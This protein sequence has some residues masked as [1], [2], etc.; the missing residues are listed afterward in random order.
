MTTRLSTVSAALAAGWFLINLTGVSAEEPASGPLKAVTTP[1]GVSVT[2]GDRPVLFYQSAPK[3]LNGRYE[4][5]N[6]IHPLYDLDGNVLTEDFPKDH[7]HQRGIYWAWHQVWVGDKRIGDPWAIQDFGWNVYRIEIDDKSP[8]SVSILAHVNWQSPLWRDEAGQP[9]PLVRETSR[10]RV[11]RATADSRKIDFEIELL[12]LQPDLKIG[13][14][15]DEKGYGG[16]SVRVR[17]PSDVKFTGPKGAV[18]PQFGAVPAGPWMDIS[19]TYSG[20]KTSGVAI[21]CHP[22]LP[23]FPQPWVLRSS[24]SMQNPAWPGRDTVTLPHIDKALLLRYQLV[25]HRGAP[26]A[27]LIN[28][29][30]AD[31]AK[32]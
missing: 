32:K 30:Q 5:S 26:S 12:A 10:V 1:E 14:S 22:T 25:L 9:R 11:H 15:E 2:E 16:F 4:R 24:R 20:D 3:S 27:E 17:L 21:L 13:G 23:G 31:Y 29:W 28:E 8:D 19:A 18:E 6:Y 7:L